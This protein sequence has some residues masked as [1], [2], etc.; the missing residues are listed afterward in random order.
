MAS[1]P[2]LKLAYDQ[3]VETQALS[4]TEF[5]ASRQSL[6]EAEA[7]KQRS[8]ERGTPSALITDVRPS[9]QSSIKYTLTPE[10]IRQIFLEYP[11]VKR[12]YD[13]NVPDKLTEKEFWK[14][15]FQSQYF[16]R[17]RVT[18]T[19]L[20]VAERDIF[21]KCAEEDE[22][23]FAPPTKRPRL[24]PTT[25]VSGEDV[26]PEGYG[27]ADPQGA[28]RQARQPKSL[29]L[30]RRYNRHGALVLGTNPTGEGERRMDD[31]DLTAEKI[32]QKIADA[33]RLQ[34][35]EETEQPK[36]TPLLINDPRR[37]FE[38]H[39]SSSSSTATDGQKSAV[40]HAE[41]LAAFSASLP[42]EQDARA[43]TREISQALAGQ[44]LRELQ[45]AA[46]ERGKLSEAIDVEAPELDAALQQELFGHFIAANELLR[47]F[48]LAHKQ[49]VRGPE[50]LAK[51]ARVTPSLQSRRTDLMARIAQLSPDK[52]TLAD[53]LCGPLLQALDHAVST[54][55][56]YLKA[57]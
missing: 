26:L 10:I 50:A 45:Q 3:L 34:D 7:S 33:T 57:Q 5:W 6:L 28:Q 15:Y 16:H 37:Y 32:R 36:L 54:G 49:S 27:M 38:G 40:S 11:G 19:T 4:A 56:A 39:S 46:A 51:L 23:A 31:A 43:T 12:A 41:L 9:Q 44:V 25:D 48:W 55:A 20:N 14:R 42:R 22:K 35:L 47:H 21:D 8:Q 17:D 52:K 18:G 53:S 13:E 1:D 24:D 2:E 30:I 29:S